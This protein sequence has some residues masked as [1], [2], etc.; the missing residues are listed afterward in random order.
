MCLF[1]KS[2][3]KMIKVWCNDF[4]IEKMVNCCGIGHGLMIVLM[5]E[6]DRQC[7]V[8]EWLVEE[9]VM[10]QKFAVKET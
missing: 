5:N 7:M 2:E 9:F 10:F 4:L 3:T 1:R 6:K 8:F